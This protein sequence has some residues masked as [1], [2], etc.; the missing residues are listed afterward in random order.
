MRLSVDA[1]A[2]GVG[3]FVPRRWIDA[4]FGGVGNGVVD[5]DGNW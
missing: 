5:S 1:V 2:D 4:V 3:V